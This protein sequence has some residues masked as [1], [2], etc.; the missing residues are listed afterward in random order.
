MCVC[1]IISDI[2]SHFIFSEQIPTEMVDRLLKQTAL[3]KRLD[4]IAPDQM[5]ILHQGS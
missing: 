1:V 5:R 2:T 3:V 4:W